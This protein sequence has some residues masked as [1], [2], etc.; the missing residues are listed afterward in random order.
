ML[1]I[2]SLLAVILLAESLGD[3]LVS[4]LK[5]AYLP[6]T[7][8]GVF[9]AALILLPEGIA[10]TRSAL[11]SDVQR[12]INILHGSAVSTIG[13]TIP[14]VLIVSSMIGRHAELGLET[15]EIALFAATIF[16]SMIQF[17]QGKTNMLQGFV[18]LMLFALWIAMLMDG[19]GLA[20][21]A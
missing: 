9:I 10:A 11:K 5:K 7:L 8:Q 3:L 19:E 20:P 12:T 16:V 6:Q 17:S 1:L 21:P 15:P 18:H 2:V 14:A 13:L 4:T